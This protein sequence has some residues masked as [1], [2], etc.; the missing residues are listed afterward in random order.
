MGRESRGVKIEG[1]VKRGLDLMMDFWDCF[2]MLRPKRVKV[3][4]V[5]VGG[6][7]GDAMDAADRHED[8]D[9]VDLLSNEP[10]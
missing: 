7:N 1:R 3:G 9:F 5:V 6:G 4:S 10:N 8:D 2:L